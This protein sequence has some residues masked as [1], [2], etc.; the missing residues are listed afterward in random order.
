MLSLPRPII[1]QKRSETRLRERVCASCSLR[2]RGC[3]PQC[4]LFLELPTVLNA[5]G[6]LDP[7]LANRAAAIRHLIAQAARRQPRNSPL[8]KHRAIFARVIHEAVAV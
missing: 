7:M 6:R 5:A 4:P 8:R 2:R 1:V 3:E